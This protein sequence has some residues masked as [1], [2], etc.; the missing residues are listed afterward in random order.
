MFETGVAP[1]DDDESKRQDK[2]HNS[3]V[4]LSFANIN[5]YRSFL[6]ESP[7]RVMS[8]YN[9]PSQYKKENHPKLSQ[10]IMSAAMGF[11]GEGS[12]TSSKY[13]GKRAISIQATE[14]LLKYAYIADSVQTPHK[15]TASDQSLHSLPTRSSMQNIEKVKIF[16][17]NL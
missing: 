17:K 4:S 14:V 2:R 10:I 7:H 12:R 8:T 11:F 9:I 16:T 3:D 1:A 5:V 6:L 13:R 15:N